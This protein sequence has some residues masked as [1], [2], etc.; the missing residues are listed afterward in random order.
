MGASSAGAVEEASSGGAVEE[1]KSFG[2]DL[3]S[4]F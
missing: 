3:R 4:Y 1:E 2:G